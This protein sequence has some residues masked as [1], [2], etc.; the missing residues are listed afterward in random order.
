MAMETQAA[1]NASSTLGALA[2]D[3][4]PPDII[5]SRYQLLQKSEPI[6]I[7]VQIRLSASTV[8]TTYPESVYQWLVEVLD[9]LIDFGQRHGHYGTI[10]LSEDEYQWLD[11]I[12]EELIYSVGENQSHPLAPLMKFIIRIIANYEQAYV[13]KLTERFPELAEEGTTEAASEN[14]QPVSNI[15]KQSE[16]ELAAH[17]FF[18][19]GFLLYHGNRIEKAISAYDMAIA[20]KPDLWEAYHDSTWIH[21]GM[22]ALSGSAEVYA[23][24]NG[25][26]PSN[27]IGQR[28]GGANKWLQ[29]LLEVAAFADA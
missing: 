17:A 18:S 21:I 9:G 24:R 27:D 13:P 4:A 28:S 1:L 29:R 5:P 2:L 22:S 26:A 14:K 25:T 8:P 3:T 16:S 7:Q 19:I 12:L 15:F 10:N 20:L 11:D 23:R 6:Q